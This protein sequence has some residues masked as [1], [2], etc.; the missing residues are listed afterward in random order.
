VAIIFTFSQG[1]WL[2]LAAGLIFLAAFGWNKKITAVA[3][4]I[5]IILTLVIPQIRNPLWPVLTFTDQSG[6]NRLAL[7]QMSQNFLL[8]SPKN[9]IFGA[10]IFGFSQIENQ[11]RNPAQLEAL[12]YPHNII[13]NFWL[14]LGLLG[15]I[16]FGWLIIKFF[17]QGL[18][19][20]KLQTIN[21]KLLSLGLLAGMV[22]VLV[23]GLID[24]PYFKNDLALLFW[25]IVALI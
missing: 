5:I 23:H 6:Q 12:L 15:L 20:C 21:C 4:L 7:W 18:Q 11:A 3:V 16:G 13:L 8:S 17:K 22:A 10:G 25:I 24:V 1:T 9:F 19:A 14:E 2:G